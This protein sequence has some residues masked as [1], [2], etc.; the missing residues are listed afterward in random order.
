MPGIRVSTSVKKIDVN[1]NGEYIE[2]NFSDSSFP[3][4]FFSM[5]ENIQ[6][7]GEDAQAQAAEID[8]KCGG[9]KDANMRAI[10]ALYRQVHTDIMHEVDAFFGPETCRKVFGNIVPGFELFNEFF[11]QLIPYF[12]EYGRERA[13]KLSKYSAARTGNV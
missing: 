9:D 2:L 6:R 8:E 12:E 7:R 1:D 10:A 5:M 4:R 11:D 13:A 3:D